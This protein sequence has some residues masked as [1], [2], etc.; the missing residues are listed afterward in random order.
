MVRTVLQGWK[1]IQVQTDELERVLIARV[2]GT[3]S[4]DRLG[5]Y[6]SLAEAIRSLLVEGALEP[7]VRVGDN[8][9]YP[10]LKSRYRRKVARAGSDLSVADQAW[11]LQLHPRISTFAYRRSP[12][13]LA[14]DRAWLR[15]LDLF[16]RRPDAQAILAIAAS[17]NER[18]LE[19]FGDE[20]FL[21]GH[22]VAFLKRVHIEPAYLNLF[23]PSEPFFYERF[24][25]GA[26][27]RVLVI[28]NLD[29]YE[30]IRRVMAHGRRSLFG[31][32]DLLIW[33]EGKKIISS[34]GYLTALPGYQP[35]T[36]IDYFGD[37]DAEGLSILQ[38]T[39]ER[40]PALAIRPC[41][42]LYESLLRI[43]IARKAKAPWEPSTPVLDCLDSRLSERIVEV[44]ERGEWYPQEG[45]SY[46]Y[47]IE[48]GERHP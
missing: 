20:K 48:K 11:L 3:E 34:M 13:L 15:S 31:P 42:P 33:G 2:G 41:I 47:F 35:E 4:Y 8:G 16:L 32:C 28:E 12:T 9:R 5:G 21:R 44:S 19:I 24:Q 14:E 38:S 25:P 18:S 30:S 46:R 6:P 7:V 36:I 27:E 40:H 43:G 17:I 26:L 22:G 29:T 39:K 1:T 37:I 45:L 10:A 23:T